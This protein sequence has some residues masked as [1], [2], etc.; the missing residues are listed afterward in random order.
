MWQMTDFTRLRFRPDSEVRPRGP[1]VAALLLGALCLLPA[2]P[3]AAAPTTLSLHVRGDLKEGGPPAT[4]YA[5][6]DT[7][8][9]TSGTTVTVTVIEGPRCATEGSD[10][11]LASATIFIPEGEANGTTTITVIDD[12]VYD[13]GESV[14]LSASSTNPT[15]ASIERS[16]RI[17]D[18]D[19]PSGPGT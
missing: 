11:S 13:D 9:L 15:L 17:F 1:L 14:C 5:L 6:M 3:A 19:E 7:G 8:A 16:F 18:N 12:S 10:F 2:M 4:L